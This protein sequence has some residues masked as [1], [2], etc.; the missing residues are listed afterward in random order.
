M[1]D[2]SRIEAELAI[3][4]VEETIPTFFGNLEYENRFATLTGAGYVDLFSDSE[5]TPHIGAGAG[6]AYMDS[7][8]GTGKET[9]A[10]FTYFAEVG[11]SVSNLALSYRY[12]VAD[13]LDMNMFLGSIRFW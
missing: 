2:A 8:L 10:E 6:V 3:V 12:Q 4:R 13:D 11:I 1:G 7:D 5:F 9:S